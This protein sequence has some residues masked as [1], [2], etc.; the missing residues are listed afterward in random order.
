MSDIE[1]KNNFILYNA[2]SGDVTLN[3]LLQ[4]ETIWLT[5]KAMAEL[6]GVV[7]STIS[8]HLPNIYET[9]ELHKQSTIR[10][11]R[12]VQQEGDRS[13]NRK[14]EYYNLDAVISDFDKQIKKLKK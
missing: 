7:K 3:V 14:L 8:E 9:N 10:K 1:P 5:Q 4:N 6:F 11:F 12:T 13:V 2:P